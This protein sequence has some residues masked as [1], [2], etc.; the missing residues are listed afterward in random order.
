VI[1]VNA[2]C[3]MLNGSMRLWHLALGIRHL[4]FGID[5]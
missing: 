4:E 5:E 1:G 3:R 2:E